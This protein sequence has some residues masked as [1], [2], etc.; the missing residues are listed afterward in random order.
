[1]NAE[2]RRLV[3]AESRKVLAILPEGRDRD[4]KCGSKKKT[5]FHSLPFRCLSVSA[6]ELQ[7]QRSLDYTLK[8]HRLCRIA[9]LY[10]YSVPARRKVY[11]RATGSRSATITICRSLAMWRLLLT[12]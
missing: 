12:S 10:Q 6:R 1:M 11:G 3:A 4:A 7:A 5:C 9:V 2:H 8:S